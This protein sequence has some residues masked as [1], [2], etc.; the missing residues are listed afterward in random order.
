[1][2]AAHDRIAIS[3][4]LGHAPREDR[5][6]RCGQ[7]GSQLVG[8]WRRLLEVRA[9]E[10]DLAVARERQAPGQ[11]PEGDRGEAVLVGRAVEV[12]PLELLGCHVV[13]RP[14]QRAGA[15]QAGVQAA[16]SGQS[17]VGQV[18]ML[19]TLVIPSPRR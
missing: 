13:E 8:R 9:D 16:R 7:L 15:R 19:A 3:G 12:T 17:E 4:R 1:M 2:N 11:R 10:R 18:G 6:D 14:D 5:V